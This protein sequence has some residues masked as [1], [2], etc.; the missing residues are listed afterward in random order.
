MAQALLF[1]LLG[2]ETSSEKES[3]FH[4]I[5]KILGVQIDL[6]ESIL[7]QFTVCNVES[8]VT[9]LVATIG[10]IL[11]KGTMAAAEMRVFAEVQIFGRLT[12]L[13]MQNL[14]RWEQGW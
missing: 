14:S 9:E 2:W 4:A 13:H 6:N 8:R 7:G 10:S 11:D 12:G 3:E 5:A 1:R